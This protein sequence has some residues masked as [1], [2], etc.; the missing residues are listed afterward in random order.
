[1]WPHRLAPE[2]LY[3][4]QLDDAD[5]IE[6]LL[7]DAA[8]RAGFSLLDTRTCPFEP[9]G[10]TGVAIVG[11]SHLAIHTWPE[12]GFATVEIFVC[13]ESADPWRA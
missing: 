13:D 10:V 4:A 8:M 9:Q 5:A 2:H 7:R 3:P 1:M 12:Y 11:E 6:D